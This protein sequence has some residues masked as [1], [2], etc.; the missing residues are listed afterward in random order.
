MIYDKLQCKFDETL[1]RE[2]IKAK[3]Y[4]GNHEF[5]CF[6]RRLNDGLNQ[7]DT[8]TMFYPVGSPVCQGTIITVKDEYFI[9]LNCETIENTVYYKS[10]VIKCNGTI[11]TDDADV[12][13]LPF[14]GSGANSAYPSSGGVS[15]K[16]ISV[17][18]GQTEIITE[19]CELARKLEINDRFN[20]WG[21][22]WKIQN[23]FYIDGIVTLN[24]QVQADSEIEYEYGISF[25]DIYPSGYK[26]GDTIS[27]DAVATINGK[28]TEDAIL[29]YSSSNADVAIIDQDGNIEF[30]GIGSVSFTIAWGE[31][32]IVK[33]TNETTIE[34]EQSDVVLLDV[35]P[36]EE[37]Y[38]GLFDGE[39]TA[40][41]RKNGE[42]VHDIAF[43]AVVTDCDFA[44]KVTIICDQETGKIIANVSEKNFNL[45][46]K[47]FTL[48]V[49][50]PE[51]G[52]TNRQTVKLKVLY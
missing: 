33:T 14:Y 28:E 25:D 1:N 20:A 38:I 22:S 45:A 8:M 11:S 17:I 40:I 6:F 37:V 27:L 34:A 31:H 18:N 4:I 26:I 44:D 10:S 13:N 3:T 29:V 7:R 32:G 2:G 12:Y 36:M 43:T 52:L 24:I 48:L 15:T 50:V 35:T 39:C 16:N 9:C 30:I 5:D 47:T 41:I 49:S 51:W 19:D 46:N 21:R 42:F 23:I